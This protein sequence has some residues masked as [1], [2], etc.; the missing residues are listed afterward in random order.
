MLKKLRHA[1]FK[2]CIV[3]VENAG[4]YT[5]LPKLSLLPDI[6]AFDNIKDGLKI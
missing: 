1:K 4:T 3:S 6:F 2:R 5:D